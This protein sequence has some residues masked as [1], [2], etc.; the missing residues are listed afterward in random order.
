MRQGFGV[1]GL[2]LSDPTMPHQSVAYMKADL[3]ADDVHAAGLALTIE[4]LSFS[5]GT[6]H[7][8]VESMQ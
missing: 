6:H 1:V 3:N 2:G 4:P 8:A 7:A 5:R